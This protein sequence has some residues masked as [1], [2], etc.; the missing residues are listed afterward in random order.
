MT[1]TIQEVTSQEVEQIL[2]GN[3]SSFVRGNKIG[4][5]SN[6]TS[7]PTEAGHSKVR[8]QTDRSSL[9]GFGQK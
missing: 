1:T 6:R 5:S 4:R 2:G 8:I 7:D 3:D 9:S